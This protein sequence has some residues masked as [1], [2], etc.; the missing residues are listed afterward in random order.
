MLNIQQSAFAFEVNRNF[1]CNLLGVSA[2]CVRGAGGQVTRPHIESGTCRL[3]RPV[4]K[5]LCGDLKK[6]MIFHFHAI[7]CVWALLNA[8]A[9]LCSGGFLHPVFQTNGPIKKNLN[10]SSLKELTSKTCR[11]I[12]TPQS[13]A[14]VLFRLGSET[15][16]ATRRPSFLCHGP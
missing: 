11:V 5:K 12:Q 15:F 6:K 3:S 1:G 9:Q 2:A 4:E 7:F 13:V 16:L 8:K 10:A 14:L